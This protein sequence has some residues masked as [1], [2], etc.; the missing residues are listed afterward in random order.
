MTPPDLAK[1]VFPEA[2][3][4]FLDHAIWARTGFPGFFSLKEGQTVEDRMREQLIEFR[5]ALDRCPDDKRLCDHCCNFVADKVWHCW[6]CDWS[7]CFDAE[8]V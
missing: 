8:E 7:R 2:D 4:A 6:E 5:D 1:E 3:E